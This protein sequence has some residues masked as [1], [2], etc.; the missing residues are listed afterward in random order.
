MRQLLFTLLLTCS[1]PSMAAPLDWSVVLDG[2]ERVFKPYPNCTRGAGGLSEMEC[3]NF[4]ARALKR[5][6]H[7]WEANSFWREGRS[8]ENEAASRRVNSELPK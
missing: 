5:F 3:S 6:L 1:L 4:R 7:E 2:F 8:V